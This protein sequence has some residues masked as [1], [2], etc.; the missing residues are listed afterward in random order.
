M[1]K[2]LQSYPRQFRLMFFG[3]LISTVGSSMIWPFLMIYV[4]ERLDLPLSTV[5]GLTSINAATGLLAAFLAGP[6]TDRFGRKWVMVFAL[7]A[8]GLVYV[9]QSQADSLSAFAV[10]MAISG[11]F[12]PLYRVAS[13]AMLADLIPA[14]QRPEAY[15]L[16]RMSNN[17]GIAVGPAL[18]GFIATISYTVAFYIAA[19]GLIAYGLL[20]FAFAVETLPQRS[21]V[22]PSGAQMLKGYLYILKDS[23]FTLFALSFVLTQMCAT[24]M[25]VLLPVFAKTEYKIPENVYGWIPTTNALMVVFLQIYVTMF[26]RKR[27]PL[28]M[29]AL[30]TF[31]YAI[32][33]GS[34]ALGHGFGGFWV[35]M[36][37]MTI[38]ELIA[39]PTASTYVAALAPAEMR[40]RYM[41]VFSLTWNVAYGLAPRIGGNLY[42]YVSPQAPWIAGLFIGLISVLA[43]LML[44]RKWSR[45]KAS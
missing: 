17:T 3:M 22:S 9:F 10:L 5:T 15:A 40:G 43:Y 28:P 42:D 2:S 45:I 8:N 25:W 27:K 13:D 30:G 38:G 23:H 35:S 37:V 12:N 44:S 16:L 39:M 26:T 7:F 29:M 19:A 18:G 14:D 31:F 21:S 4:K 33:V 6:I 1:L 36:V 11:I 34:I 20:M 24:L 32:G 41:S